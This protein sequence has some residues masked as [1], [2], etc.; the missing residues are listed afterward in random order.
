VITLIQYIIAHNIFIISFNFVTD[1]YEITKKSLYFLRKKIQACFVRFTCSSK[2]NSLSLAWSSALSTVSTFV[3]PRNPAME[4]C[5]PSLT[6]CCS[7]RSW[8]TIMVQ[9]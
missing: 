5:H 4:I 7:S 9:C 2:K 6:H 8:L 1:H 3:P